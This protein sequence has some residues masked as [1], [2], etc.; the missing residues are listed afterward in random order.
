LGLLVGNSQENHELT[1]WMLHQS[2]Q[3][4]ENVTFANLFV[5]S[6][7]PK[8]VTSFLSEF[9]SWKIIIVC[10]KNSSINSE[11]F[12][13]IARRFDV[14]SNCIVNDYGLVT[15]LKEYVQTN[16]IKDHLFLFACSTLGNF[17]IRELAEIAPE[18]TYIDCGSTLN[19]FL[20]L[21]SDRAYLSAYNKVDYRGGVAPLDA[22]YEEE[23]WP[24]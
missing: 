20:G 19:P 22:M 16:K 18:N 11:I 3:K 5:N 17:C 24:W 2:G 7:Y 1:A 4:V 15:E 14:G 12:P 6:N 9:K 8:F 21:S 23:S 10:N 13:N